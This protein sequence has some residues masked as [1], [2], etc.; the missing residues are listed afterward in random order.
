MKRSPLDKTLRS[1]GVRAKEFGMQVTMSV[2][3]GGVGGWDNGGKEWDE[4]GEGGGEEVEGWG[5]E[6]TSWDLESWD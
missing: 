4:W 1:S 2:D 6:E 5:K 3:N